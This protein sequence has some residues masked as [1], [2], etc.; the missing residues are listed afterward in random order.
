MKASPCGTRR[1]ARCR[2]RHV[3]PFSGWTASASART[4]VLAVPD[5]PSG[6]PR[7]LAAEPMTRLSRTTVVTDSSGRRNATIGQAASLRVRPCVVPS[8]RLG[9][10]ALLSV[11]AAFMAGAQSAT[12][13]IGSTV[14]CPRCRI[15]VRPGPRVGDTEGQGALV[16]EP[17]SLSMDRSG[18]I[19]LTQFTN[20]QPPLVFD[21]T[22]RFLQ[23]L[24][25]LGTGPGEYRSAR[26]LS[27]S[28]SDSIYVADMQTGRMTILGPDLKFAR[29]ATD[30]WLARAFPFTVLA[31]GQVV[32][33]ADVTTDSR[34][35]YP[36]HLYSRTLKY[37]KSF[38]ADT[39]LFRPDRRMHSRRRL[40]P[41]SSGGVWAAHV[42]EYVIDRFDATGRRDLRVLR[43]VP[44]FEPHDAPTLNVDPE[45]KPLITAISEDALGRLWVFTLV[46]DSRWKGALG[47]TLP[48]R[49]GGGRSPIPVIL[50]HDRYFD[51]IIEVIDVRA[52]R[53]VVSQ[54]V[55]AA[56]MFAFGRDH[57][58]ARREDSTGAFYIQLWRLAV[59]G[60]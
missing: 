41:A 8:T 27:V 3:P 16:A 48:S 10:T 26:L 57:A 34:I 13:Y 25:R 46:K 7:I 9:L 49:L 55:D 23:Q 2:K 1:E 35:G 43:R 40:A 47:S 56:L 30:A 37:E 21:S 45:P 32:V 52:L 60:L 36:L 11:S 5:V 51:T 54:R 20:K 39:P 4:K 28:A 17:S 29:S 42:T 12:V 15:D 14:S 50:D 44:W 53:L 31:Q 6:P 19:F 38:G 24:G 33:G 22:G 59:K 58:A 18:R